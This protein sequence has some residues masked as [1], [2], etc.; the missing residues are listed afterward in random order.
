MLFC[1]M[2]YHV[3]GFQSLI[4]RVGLI[5]VISCSRCSFTM[6]YS[7][8]FVFCF[9]SMIACK[10]DMALECYGEMSVIQ[11]VDIP[12]C[13]YNVTILTDS[14]SYYLYDIT[15][16]IQHLIRLTQDCCQ[17]ECRIRDTLP[18]CN[19]FRCNVINVAGMKQMRMDGGPTADQFICL[20]PNGCCVAVGVQGYVYFFDSGCFLTNSE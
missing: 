15:L 11:H 6:T 2:K 9:K 17:Y 5:C 20:S 14:T 7:V 3:M 18:Y 10:K 16:I 13:L 1:L 8:N 19:S 4:H 12:E